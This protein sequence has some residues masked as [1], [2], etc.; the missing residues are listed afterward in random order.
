MYDAKQ[1]LLWTTIDGRKVPLNGRGYV[2]GSTHEHDYMSYDEANEALTRV[3]CCGL[4]FCFTKDDPFVGIDLDDCMIDEYTMKPWAEE[5]V[6][7]LGSYTELSPSLT[8]VKIYGIGS[9]PDGMSCEAKCEDGAIEVYEHGRFFAVTESRIGAWDFSDC[10]DGINWLHETHWP[11]VEA[12]EP[13]VYV[14]INGDS[15]LLCR[16]SSYVRDAER[17]E[18]G[19]NNAA[20]RLSGH[21]HALVDSDGNRLGTE[22]VT[23]LILGWNASLPKPMVE[24][25]ARDAAVNGG[26]NGTRRPDK[27]PELRLSSD[28]APDMDWDRLLNRATLEESEPEPTPTPKPEIGSF[29]AELYEIPG[30]IGEFVKHATETAFYPQPQLAL[31]NAIALLGTLTGRKVCDKYNSRTNLYALG[32]APSGA[33]KDHSRRLAKQICYEAEAHSLIGPERLAS[34]AGLVSQIKISPAILFQLDEFGKVLGTLQNGQK[35][36]HLYNIGTVL[37]ELYSSV[38]Q[39]WIGDAYADPDKTPKID[40]PH[41]VVYA[42]TTPSTL[43]DGL[44]AENLTDG[45]LA[46]MAIF[47]GGYVKMTEPKHRNR[48]EKLIEMAREWVDYNPG[49]GNIRPEPEVMLYTP[50]AEARFLSHTRQ[51]SDRLGGE[52]LAR[53]AIWSRVAERSRKLAMIFAC[54]RGIGQ[55]ITIED[56]EAG[57]RLSNWTCRRL[58]GSTDKVTENQYH[59]DIV[60]VE[61]IIKDAGKIDGSKLC[62]ATR[63]LKSKERA[64]I[65]KELQDLGIIT[66]EP[67]ETKGRTRMEIVWVG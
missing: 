31:G 20:F 33:G 3:L 44:T 42:T 65:V 2:S 14:P 24:K 8:G 12:Y 25:R 5:I 43:W 50:E 36:P 52:S 27:P 41:C 9:K 54:S 16:A 34:S 19:R 47:E 15:D 60:R 62:R 4:A 23:E 57:I 6:N 32:V 17:P 38:G 35:S 45:L 49:G 55:N 26:T 67:V 40:D 7:R 37:M 13:R 46:R 56:A 22:Q 10:Q 18:S 11:K 21:L 48:P 28:P 30:F 61:S 58:V 51:I 63:W 1:W 53:A 66:V 59:R 29:P 39:I 64:D